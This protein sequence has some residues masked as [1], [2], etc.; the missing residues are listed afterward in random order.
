MNHH[1][2]LRTLPIIWIAIVANSTLLLTGNPSGWNHVVLIGILVAT[3]LLAS[4][5]LLVGL[6][7]VTMP[8]LPTLPAELWTAREREI[9]C[10]IARGYTNDEIA[11]ELVVALSTVKTHINNIYRKLGVSS[12]AQAVRRALELNIT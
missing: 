2:R 4:R 6:Q 12:R 1:H 8:P 10:L 3:G 11:A 9:L 5:I 7:V